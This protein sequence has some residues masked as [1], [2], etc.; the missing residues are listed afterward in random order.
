[1]TYPIDDPRDPNW[2]PGEGGG[3][4]GGG[5]GEEP[6]GALPGLAGYLRRRYTC[7]TVLN[8]EMPVIDFLHEAIFISSRM[9]MTQAPNGKIRLQ[10][11]K[12]VD[13]ALGLT[14]LTGTTID[15]D[16]ASPWITDQKYFLLIDPHTNN[17]EVR[18]VTGAVYSEDQNDVTLTGDGIFD[19]T[20]FAGGDADT[21]AQATVEVTSVVASTEYDITLDG[22]TITF[23]TLDGDTEDTVAAFLAGAFRGHPGL[24]RKFRFSVEGVIVTITALFGT[25]TL[26]QAL[27]KTHTAPLADPVDAPVLSSSAGSLAA[28]TYQV[29]YTFVNAH[30][31]TL[32]SPFTAITL[33]ADKQIDVDAVTL[34]TGATSVRWYVVPE[35]G[36]GRLRYH[37]E[38]DG[39]AFSI[40]SLP[41]LTASLPPDLNR[42]GTEVLRVKAK[43]TDREDTRSHSSQSNVLRASFEW[44]LGNRRSTKNRIDLKYRDS[45]QDWRLIELR[46]RDDAHIAKVH[47]VLNE[48]VNGQA[49]DTYFQAYRIAAGLLA[50]MRDADFFYK[51]K[52]SREALLLEEGDVVCITDDGA[53]VVNLPVTIEEISLDLNK[54]SMPRVSFTG[55]KYSTTL[56]DDSV[57][58]R[59]IP[60]VHESV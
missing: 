37:S 25:L 4:G 17:S 15:V 22:R 8:E 12:P 9:F 56:Y 39:S 10:N 34:P 13:W 46:L 2:I 36:S 7:N 31:Q 18:V 42:T 26:D 48:E 60:V 1:M 52:A 32:P 6:P 43:F 21:P 35:A 57:V 53:G 24:N 50:E 40:D 30:G 29:L 49:I 19:I 55:M 28:G 59:T 47:K 14:A 54:A 16:D 5:G 58:E 38:N 33:L 45:G 3:S 11:K 44:A 51:W 41:K 20:G 23:V 27:E